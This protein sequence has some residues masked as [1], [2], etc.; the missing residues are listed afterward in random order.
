M[1]I[2]PG[3]P[4]RTCN[5]CMSGKYNVC[6]KASFHNSVALYPGC[7]GRYYVQDA[8]LTFKYVME[9]IGVPVVW[10][11]YGKCPVTSKFHPER[12]RLNQSLNPRHP[13]PTHTHCTFPFK[14]IRGFFHSSCTTISSLPPTA[15]KRPPTIWNSAFERRQVLS[16]TR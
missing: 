2:E 13:S 15:T 7:L 3:G 4:C 1:T 14:D 12:F 9:I 16:Q 11:T 8:N 6:D 5:L 10:S